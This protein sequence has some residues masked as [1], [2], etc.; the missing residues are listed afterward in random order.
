MIHL[1]GAAAALL[2]ATTIATPEQPVSVKRIGVAAPGRFSRT[3]SATNG[4]TMLLVYN[5]TRGEQAVRLDAAGRRLEPASIGLPISVAAV[6]WNGEQW[7]LLNGAQFIRMSA[8]GELLDRAARPLPA[9][10][11]GNIFQAVWT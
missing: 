10:L 11:T 3:V 1:I 5:D 6:V 4:S 2:L 7:V 9:T 8:D